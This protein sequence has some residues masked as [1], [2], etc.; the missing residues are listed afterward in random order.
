[1]T[2][3][4]PTLAQF[5]QRSAR[6]IDVA[7][8]RPWLAAALLIAIGLI[9]L[10][11]GLLALPPVDRT[12]VIYAESSRAMLERGEFLDARFLEQRSPI[13]PI[14]IYWLQIASGKLFGAGAWDSITT[15]RIPS[16]LAGLLAVLAVWWLLRPLL[17]PQASLIA[18]AFY[19]VTPIVALQAQL[20]IPE[21]PLL[22]A[23]ALAQ[24]SLLRI[25]CAGE[26]ERHTGL[27]IMFWCAQGFGILLNALAAPIL[28]LS[29][30]IALFIFDRR[31]GWLMRLRPLW[32]LPL[33]I[34]IAAPWL[35]VRAHFDG[36]VP[37]QSLTWWKFLKAL[38]GAQDMKW[39]AAPFTFTLAL[40]LGFL[41]GAVLLVP[42]VKGLWTDRAA[43]LQRFLFAWL[44]GYLAYLE[45]VASKPALYTVQAVFPAAAA[46][47]ALALGRN[48]NL[49]IPAGMLRL[50]WWLMLAVMVVYFASV[51]WLA[52]TPPGV[53]IVT[54]AIVITALFT[55]AAITA[56]RNLAAAWLVSIVAGVALLLGFTFGV[57]LPHLERV[58]PAARIA[59]ATAPLQ[60][61]VSGPVRVVGFRE[62]STVFVLGRQSIVFPD[63]LAAWI[64]GGSEGI[65]VVEDRWDGEVQAELLAR[66]AKLGQR[67]GCIEAF[68]IMR[69]CPLSFSIYVTGKQTLDDSCSVAPANVCKGSPPPHGTNHN[70]SR[71]Y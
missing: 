49:E 51:L 24:L 34:V 17:G 64:A 71:C 53:F 6:A 31:L 54:G 40:I 58:W 59:E 21:G 1:M 12:E 42:A 45:L 47:A 62:P 8:K 3:V 50:P 44:I 10:L 9:C 35:L 56:G 65:A 5:E 52:G 46:T 15:Y 55:L 19:A 68:N 25:Y 63:K 28:S 66:G 27:A 57:L 20:A 70:S 14:G 18:A 26:S 16:L 2:E 60:R 48:G 11:P 41:P 39:Q 13:R 36:G 30:I 33:V 32:G 7:A 67:A 38:G 22:L 29:T 37:F 43:A 23:M 69:G 61:C 4:S